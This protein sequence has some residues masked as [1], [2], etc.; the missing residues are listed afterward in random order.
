MARIPPI[1]KLFGTE[2]L[3]EARKQ[4]HWLLAKI[5][6]VQ[7]N[8]LPLNPEISIPRQFFHNP[9]YMGKIIGS[10]FLYKYDPKTKEKLPYYD[11]FPLT[12]PIEPYDDGFLGLNLHYLSI[13][14][15]IPLLNKLISLVNS[16]SMTGT[17]YM[18]VSYSLLKDSPK[19]KEFVP[20]VKRYLYSH[21]T[22]SMLVIQPSEWMMT[23]Y[24]PLAE[25]KKASQGK[26]FAD[27]RK[28]IYNG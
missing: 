16:P 17:T 14:L 26:V 9:T 11:T 18:R 5:S 8:Q 4:M 23:A 27:S 1:R 12:I 20:C 28:K 6:G 13:P 15:R 7:S 22:S 24:L 2:S 3:S 19:Y 10:M 25:F 21:I